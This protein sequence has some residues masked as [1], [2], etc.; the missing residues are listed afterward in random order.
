[1]KKLSKEQQRI[2]DLLKGNPKTFVIESIYWDWNIV[3]T[4]EQDFDWTNFKR[5]TF[6]ILVKL[7]YLIK[8]TDS[9]VKYK[10]WVLNPIHR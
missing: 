6:D 4:N 10:K 8:D 2:V 5:P 9:G 1:M 7:C 3:T